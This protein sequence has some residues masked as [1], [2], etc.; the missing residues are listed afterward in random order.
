VSV[1]ILE[2][3]VSQQLYH[4]L[5]TVAGYTTAALVLGTVVAV[6]LAGRLKRRTFGLELD[7]IADLLQE[8]EAMLHGIRDGVVTLDATRRVTLVNDAAR[9]LLQIRSS[10]LGQRLA[11][12]IPPSRLDDLLTSN[13]GQ[14]PSLGGHADTLLTDRYCLAIN[15]MPVQLQGRPLGAVVT[16]NDRTEVEELL[17]E[18]D[19]VRSF[20]EALRA[21]Q[22]EIRQPDAHAC[23][24]AGTGRERRGDGLRVGD[25]RNRGRPRA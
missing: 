14:R 6:A 16:V 21:Q 18:L 23:R 22:H 5:P 20:S 10:G 2:E 7:E 13:T 8:R 9:R 24:P 17:R 11:D 19:S 4:A 3:R 15:R 25:L 1:G 12:L